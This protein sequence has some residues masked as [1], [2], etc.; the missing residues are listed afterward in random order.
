MLKKGLI[1]ILLPLVL[2]FIFPVKVSFL[3]QLSIIL[4]YLVAIAFLEKKY[5]IQF[6]YLSCLYWLS[7]IGSFFQNPDSYKVY[8]NLEVYLTLIFTYYITVVII[9]LFIYYISSKIKER[10][11]Q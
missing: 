9:H 10:T 11:N 3:F 8:N 2:I 4:I 7:V 1:F 5:S 6:L